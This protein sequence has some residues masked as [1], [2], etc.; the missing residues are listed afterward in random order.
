MAVVELAVHVVIEILGGVALEGG[1]VGAPD[2]IPAGV[3]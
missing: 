1:P 3:A 2:V